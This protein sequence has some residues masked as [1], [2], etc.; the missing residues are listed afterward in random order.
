MVMS[1]DVVAILHPN[2]RLKNLR[3]VAMAIFQSS[4]MR[5]RS[6]GM[7]LGRREIGVLE[8]GDIVGEEREVGLF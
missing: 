3:E 6:E 7:P 5:S 1:S 2:Q 8:G 4:V